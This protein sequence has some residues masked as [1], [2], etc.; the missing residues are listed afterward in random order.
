MKDD[1]KNATQSNQETSIRL[2][3][4]MDSQVKINENLTSTLNEIK[5]VLSKSEAM[6]VE[7]NNQSKRVSALSHKT[8]AIAN[9]VSDLKTQV[10]VNKTL[11]KQTQDLKRMF[12]ASLISMILAYGWSV[13]D[14]K[15]TSPQLTQE[16]ITA[17][18]ELIVKSN[19]EQS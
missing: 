7:M 19:K 15:P 4:F 10:A 11:V 14:K 5:T 13:Y 16:A 12:A 17:L 3:M 18:S 9:D 6:Q 1:P 8:E 2:E